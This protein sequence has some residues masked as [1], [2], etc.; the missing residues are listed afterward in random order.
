MASIVT[1]IR[2]PDD[3]SAVVRKL[4]ALTLLS[5]TEIDFL[6]GLQNNKVQVPDG[7]DFIADGADLKATYL[8]TSG[9]AIR[10]SLTEDGRRQILSFAL[11]G[12]ILGLHVN[13]RR[14]ATY[15]AAGLSQLELAVIEP[16]RIMEISQNYP[17]LAAGL[18]WC[19]AREFAILGDQTVRLGRLSA[20]ER[21][22]HLLLELWHRLRLIGETDGKWLEMPMRQTDIADTL[23]LSL[24]HVNRQLRRMQSEGLITVEKD[25]IRLNDVKKMIALASFDTKHLSEFRL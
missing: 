17:V 13:F 8:V 12:D 16:L 1:D 22:A 25:W 11:P 21:L 14:T 2:P 23:G 7:V 18:S 15:H 19:T 5:E 10:Y 4:G 9:W 20:Y 6:E 24:V 3:S